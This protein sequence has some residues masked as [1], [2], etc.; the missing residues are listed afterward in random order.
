MKIFTLTFATLLLCSAAAVAQES[1]A[2]D[3]A[4]KPEKSKSAALKDKVR[5]PDGS[6]FYVAKMEGDLDGFITA[7]I[8][9][10]KLPVVVVTDESLADYVITGVSVKGDHRWYDT[11]VTG[12]E[13]DK[14]QGNVQI[15]SVR[16]KTVIWAGEAGDR[17][18]WWGS[19]KR[20][21]RRKV[22]ERLVGKMRHAL[23]SK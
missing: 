7:E 10:R 11:V 4:R 19:L 3:G 16:D 17:S 18:L 14:H 6:K 20:G 8:S 2:D 1:A 22:A 9:K 15:V 13:R 23:F 5:I 21:G 12:I